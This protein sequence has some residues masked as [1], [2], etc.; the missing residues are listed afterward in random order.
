VFACAGR[1]P[2]FDSAAPSRVTFVLKMRTIRKMEPARA[3]DAPCED[4]RCGCGS[5]LARVVDGTVELKCRR[6]KSVWRL[7]LH[8]DAAPPEAGG[9]ETRSPAAG[10]TRPAHGPSR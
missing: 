2:P 1:R 9:H 8:A 5:L 4:A 6:C 7:S 3:G 10:R